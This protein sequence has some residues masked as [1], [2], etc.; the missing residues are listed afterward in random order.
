MACPMC[1][2]ERMLDWYPKLVIT[3]LAIVPFLAVNRLDAV[4]VLGAFVLYEIFWYYA[5]RYGLWYAFPFS[6]NFFLRNLAELGLMLLEVGAFGAGLLYLIGK[7]RFFRRQPEAGVPWWQACFY[8][9]L[10]LFTRMVI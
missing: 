3:R 7:V 6:G 9:P 10:A 4:R 8:V 1:S 5:Y 2:Y